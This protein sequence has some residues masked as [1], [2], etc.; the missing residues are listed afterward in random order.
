MCREEKIDRVQD[1]YHDAGTSSRNV[2]NLAVDVSDVV[3]GRRHRLQTSDDMAVWILEL[4]WGKSE[5]NMRVI[6][7]NGPVNVY[8]R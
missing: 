7:K 4:F 8:V 1:T 6:G 2:V 3:L 5:K